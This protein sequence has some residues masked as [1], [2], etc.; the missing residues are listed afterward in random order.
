MSNLVQEGLCK[1]TTIQEIIAELTLLAN[2]LIE[3]DLHSEAEGIAIG[4]TRLME[5]HN[6]SVK[7]MD[8]FLDKAMTASLH[9]ED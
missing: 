9:K 1:R 4:T 3:A 8:Y 5:T 6:I 2:E 7:S